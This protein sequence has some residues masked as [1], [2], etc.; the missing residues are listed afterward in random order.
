MRRRANAELPTQAPVKPREIERYL[1][2][3]IPLSKGMQVSVVSVDGAGVLLSAPLPPNVNHRGTVFGG[4]ASALGMIACWT[5]IHL[6][7][8]GLPFETALVIRRNSVEYFAPLPTDFEAFSRAPDGESWDRFL[9]ALAEEGK[10]RLDLTADIRCRGE[11][12]GRFTGEY[13]ARRV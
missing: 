8:R 1:H 9:A 3:K 2:E 7:L 10:G 5:L 6:R 4:S 12:A 11:S 13:V